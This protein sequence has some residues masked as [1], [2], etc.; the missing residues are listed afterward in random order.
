MSEITRTWII[1]FK[2]LMK[3]IIIQSKGVADQPDVIPETPLEN[4]EKDISTDDL[5]TVN[6]IA[7]K[8]KMQV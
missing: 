3:R 7:A 4:Y 2:R 1:L 6:F 5:S 8:C